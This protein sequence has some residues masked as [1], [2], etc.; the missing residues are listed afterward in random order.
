MKKYLLINDAP[1][2][3]TMFVAIAINVQPLPHNNMLYT[4]DPYVVWQPEQG[5]FA[6]WPHP[7]PPTHYYP[8]PLNN[9]HE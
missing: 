4:S 1:I 6:R 8:L 2:G 7:Y 5:K 9:D 3:K